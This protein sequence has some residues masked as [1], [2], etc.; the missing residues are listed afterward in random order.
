MLAIDRQTRNLD[1]LELKDLLSP[2]VKVVPRYQEIVR[3]HLVIAPSIVTR[4]NVS[5]H[6]F[7]VLRLHVP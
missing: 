2:K 4:G 6:F 1:L 5:R 3:F 7:G